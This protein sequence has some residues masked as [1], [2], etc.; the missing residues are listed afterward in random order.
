MK[1]CKHKNAETRLVDIPNGQLTMWNC[2]DCKL[3]KAVDFK[4]NHVDFSDYPGHELASQF[5]KNML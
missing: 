3:E 2:P 1:T 5:K 4:S